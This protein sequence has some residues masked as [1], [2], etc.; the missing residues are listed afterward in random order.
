MAENRLTRRNSNA[1]KNP[2]INHRSKFLWP[3]SGIDFAGTSCKLDVISV[4]SE[5][6]IIK[7]LPNGDLR[8]MLGS[9]VLSFRKLHFLFKIDL[10][11]ELSAKT[12]SSGQPS[13]DISFSLS[14][15]ENENFEP[16]LG[17]ER[18]DCEI[19]LPGALDPDFGIFAFSFE[20]SFFTNRRVERNVLALEELE[21]L[22][23]ASSWKCSAAK[24][25]KSLD[26][27]AESSGITGNMKSPEIGF[28][29]GSI[30][31]RASA[32]AIESSRFASGSGEILRRTKG[33]E[34]N[35]RSLRMDRWGTTCRAT[36]DC[37]KSAQTFPFCHL[38]TRLMASNSKTEFP[39]FVSRL[40]KQAPS[41]ASNAKAEFGDRDHDFSSKKRRPLRIS[42]AE[43]AG[44]PAVFPEHPAS[45]CSSSSPIGSLT[46][47]AAASPWEV[48]AS[49]F[50]SLCKSPTTSTSESNP[51]PWP[52]S[53]KEKLFES[54]MVSI[55]TFKLEREPDPGD[56]CCNK[57]TSDDLGDKSS[58]SRCLLAVRASVVAVHSC[59]DR[60]KYLTAETEFPVLSTNEAFFAWSSAIRRANFSSPCDANGFCFFGFLRVVLSLASASL[61]FK[62]GH[63]DFLDGDATSDSAMLTPQLATSLL[64]F[65][66]HE[67]DVSM[68]ELLLNRYYLITPPRYQNSNS[69][70]A[71]KVYRLV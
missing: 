18:G 34:A 40:P 29:T 70:T 42:F 26:E 38:T 45:S 60:D 53:G 8:V 5:G 46:S 6:S 49:G 21:E 35:P 36:D 1:T 61:F 19:G 7:L 44:E 67:L 41:A 32:L 62:V 43:L 2:K 64:L 28:S 11:F 15:R 54:S 23:E 16:R 51:K 52:G 37:K 20:D 56:G 59:A 9:G 47:S 3:A 27:E 10:F 68:P 30:S 33:S 14:L 71:P 57:S 31:D 48:E 12:S 25:G 50:I 55:S 65:S 24:A 63:S 13:S 39:S 17:L 22:S 4:L 69:K 66:S 58:F